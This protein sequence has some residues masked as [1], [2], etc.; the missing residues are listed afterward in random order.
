MCGTVGQLLER[1]STDL[2]SVLRV[3]QQGWCVLWTRSNCEARVHDQL[4]QKGYDVFLPQIQQWTLRKGGLQPSR[5]PMF[6]GYL[7]LHDAV[8]KHA[9]LD[10]CKADGLVAILGA[11]WDHLARVPN[12]EIAAIRRAVDSQLPTLPYPYLAEGARVRITHGTL[13]N[14][15]GILVKTEGLATSSGSLR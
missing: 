2:K 13:A 7:F 12:G 11:R 4:L 1:D 10:I 6:K 14:A 9:Y 15:E 5:V 8:D 3:E